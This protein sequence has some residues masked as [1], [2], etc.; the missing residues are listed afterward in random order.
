MVDTL[1]LPDPDDDDRD[2]GED[3]EQ[4]E[5]QEMELGQNPAVPTPAHRR[6]AVE[7]RE[8]GRQMWEEYAGGLNQRQIADMH[9]VSLSVVH[10][11]LTRFARIY[12]RRDIE[13]ARRTDLDR[14]EALMEAQ[15]HAAVT[16]GNK[17][18]VKLVL[19][20]IQLR[21]RILG[22]EAPRKVEHSGEVQAGVTP[23]L[24]DLLKERRQQNETVR[25]ELERVGAE[26][27]DAEVVVVEDDDDHH[28]D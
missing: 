20:M 11:C 15:W 2:E 23:E 24:A 19:I 3:E 6:N 18:K 4:D 8:L 7:V 13:R 1:A 17:D 25:G 28:D 21:A 12:K 9:G 26:I 16:T 14:I 10:N 22:Y 5:S 27:L